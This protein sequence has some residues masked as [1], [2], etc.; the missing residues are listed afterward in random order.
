MRSLRIMRLMWQFFFLQMRRARNATRLL[1]TPPVQDLHISGM[2]DFELWFQ[3]YYFFISLLLF[4]MVIFKKKK[5]RRRRERETK[6]KKNGWVFCRVFCFNLLS[7]KCFY[8]FQSNYPVGKKPSFQHNWSHYL[9]KG[10]T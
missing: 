1:I 9:W 2:G 10:N 6:K 5:N 3:R 8:C 4:R 7:T